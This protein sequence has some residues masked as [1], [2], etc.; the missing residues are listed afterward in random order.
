MGG[1]ADAQIAPMVT[2]N[3]VDYL[4]NGMLASRL[5]ADRMWDAAHGNLVISDGAFYLD[6]YNQ[7]DGSAR[8]KAF[9]DPL[10]PFANGAWLEK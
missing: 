1:M 3:G 7:T 5:K 8:L 2:A 4:E 6:Y 9:R 10:Y